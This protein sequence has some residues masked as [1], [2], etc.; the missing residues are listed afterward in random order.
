MSVFQKNPFLRKG[1]SVVRKLPRLFMRINSVPTDYHANP[2]VLCNSFPKSGTHLLK[3]V[4]SV[5][6]GTQD[7][8]SFIASQ[9]TLATS[10]LSL[11]V[12]QKKIKKIVAGELVCSHLEYNDALDA[13]LARKNAVH[14]FI[15]RDLRDVV[16]SETYYLTH[17]NRWHRLHSSYLQLADMEARNTL[18][19]KG[20]LMDEGLPFDYENIGDRFRNYMGWITSNHCYPVRFEDLIGPT[21]EQTVRGILEYYL[22][23]SNKELNIEEL[24]NASLKAIQPKKSHTFR[25]GKSG[26][27]KEKLTPSQLQEIN[28]LAGYEL[29]ALG[30]ETYE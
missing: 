6:P 26:G 23:Q 27:W 9:P 21:Q 15:Y 2:P 12:M 20:G 11:S 4:L 16:V 18:C 7:F 24:V 22:Q 30:Y 8:G 28:R 13:A 29:K 14:Y 17:M 5:L 19:I 3:Q 1:L 25:E 10:K